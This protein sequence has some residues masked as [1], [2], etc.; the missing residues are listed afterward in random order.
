MLGCNDPEVEGE[1]SKILMAETPSRRSQE[2]EWHIYIPCGNQEQLAEHFNW[3]AC[4]RAI[5]GRIWEVEALPL[6]C[7]W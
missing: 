6:T 2:V 5:W 7:R 4:S 3:L 1:A